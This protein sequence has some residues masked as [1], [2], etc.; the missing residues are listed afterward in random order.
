MNRKGIE[1]ETENNFD[2]KASV[3]K[4]ADES[5]ASAACWHPGIPAK[6][7]FKKS[8]Y[9]LTK[10]DSRAPQN[11]NLVQ[12]KVLPLQRPESSISAI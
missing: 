11:D 10:V 4:L 1:D 7:D 9:G 6:T 3:M 5:G 8:S 12:R 2:Y